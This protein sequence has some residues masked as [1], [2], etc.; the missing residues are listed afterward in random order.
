[1]GRKKIAGLFKKK[2]I[3]HIDK[4]LG[5]KRVCKSTGT[6][7]LVEAEKFLIKLME[8][9]RQAE[10]YGIRPKRTLNEAAGKYLD[11]KQDKRSIDSDKSRLNMLLPMLGEYYLDELHMGTLQL[12][13][14]KRKKD[15]VKNNTI[16]H[17]LK[18]IRQIV[19]CAAS[20]WIDEF[21]LT[22]LLSAPKIKLLPLTDKAPAYPLSWAEQRSLFNLLP[23][24]IH[25]MALFAVNTGCRDQEICHLRWDWEYEIEDTD[26]TVFIIPEEFVKNKKPRLV[27][28]NTVARNVINARRGVHP[29]HVFSYRGHR[30]QRILSC[31]WKKARE[32]AGLKQVRVHDLKH[33]YGKRL[34]S[35]KVS[36]EDRQDLLGHTSTRITTD[37]SGAE[38]LD[39]VEASEKV[40]ET[41][42][43]RS[44]SLTLVRKVT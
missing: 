34:R 4:Y 40:C 15:G 28:L 16:N 37:Y 13:V 24:H 12:W 27:V 18:V 11:Y 44:T 30:L 26:L 8:D 23:A 10:V 3:Y 41:K 9:T 43:G 32:L 25:D 17:G 5:G 42:G 20:E 14:D 2:D 36:F 21:G 39:L 1:M 7:N 38:I 29:E 35:A 31:G 19:N 33:T 6:A 22:W